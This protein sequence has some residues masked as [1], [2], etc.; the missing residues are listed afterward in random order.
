MWVR[1]RGPLA[2]CHRL[3]ELPRC[4]ELLG[5]ALTPPADT[6]PTP[7]LLGRVNVQGR[8]EFTLTKSIRREKLR[9]LRD[10]KE[11]DDLAARRPDSSL[12]FRCDLTPFIA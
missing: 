1:R 4:R 9:P 11:A 5:R 6:A 3:E 2:N 8:Y 12:R 10:P 7:L